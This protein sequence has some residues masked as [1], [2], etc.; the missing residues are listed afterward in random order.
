MMIGIGFYLSYIYYFKEKYRLVI[1]AIYALVFLFL[2]IICFLAG[3]KAWGKQE[4]LLERQE[5]LRTEIL[6]LEKATKLE[7]LAKT[8]AIRNHK[9]KIQ[10]RKSPMESVT[11]GELSVINGASNEQEKHR[12]KLSKEIKEEATKIEGELKEKRDQKSK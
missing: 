1:V 5:I 4:K 9:K 3:I 11:I 7:E 6:D 12:R 10:R 8:R 2:G